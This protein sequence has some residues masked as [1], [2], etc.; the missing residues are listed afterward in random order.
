MVARDIDHLELFFEQKARKRVVEEL[1]R[2]DGR[3][4]AIVDVARDDDGFGARV[5]GEPHKLVKDVRL[6][7]RQMAAEEEP[8]E[9]P[10]GGMNE[11]HGKFS[12]LLLTFV[13]KEHAKTLGGGRLAHV[14]TEQ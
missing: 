12:F 7:I 4:G 10:I 11:A 1:N 9:M 13:G 6:I 5:L 2:L 8:S 3:H 14:C